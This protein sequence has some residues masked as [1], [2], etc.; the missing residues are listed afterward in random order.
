MTLNQPVRLGWLA[1]WCWPALSRGHCS[2]EQCLPARTVFFSHP[3]PASSNNP[4]SS[5]QCRTGW[6]LRTDAMNWNELLFPI[7]NRNLIPVLVC[8][9]SILSNQVILTCIIK[10]LYKLIQKASRWSR[11][12]QLGLT[13]DNCSTRN[14]QNIEQKK[15]PCL[16]ISISPAFKITN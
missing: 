3:K 7:I 1:G 8:K 14:L 12:I 11:F 2:H 9:A 15:N 4:R 16:N 10:A 6:M 5:Q 13:F